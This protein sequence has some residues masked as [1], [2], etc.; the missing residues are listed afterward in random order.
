[1]HVILCSAKIYSS[2]PLPLRSLYGVER[3]HSVWQVVTVN[4][5]NIFPRQCGAADYYSWTPWDAV[6]GNI[7]HTS[8]P[9]HDSFLPRLLPSPSPSP[10]PL[11]Q[12]LSDDCV[13]GATVVLER[14][15]A[16]QCCLNGAGYIREVSFTRCT[17]N[18]D[19]FE[20]YETHIHTHTHTLS[21]S[22]SAGTDACIVYN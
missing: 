6:G 4:F 1:M 11:P 9:L 17:C 3:G 10:P 12:R 2:L 22:L 7:A 21:L 14:R 13:L 16:D 15:R 18:E 19:D 20:W 5:S 8:S